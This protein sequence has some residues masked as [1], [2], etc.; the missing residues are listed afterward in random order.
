MENNRNKTVPGDPTVMGVTE[1]RKGIQFTVSVSQGKA[2]L[3]LFREK[4]AEPFRIIPLEEAE[5]TGTVSSIL[6]NLPDN[7]IYTYLYR[8]GGQ[9]HIDPYARAVCPVSCGKAVQWRG[10]D[11]KSVV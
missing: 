9:F 3:Y 10:I 7:E 6:L 11:R 4:E 2:E 5:R 1:H 8:I